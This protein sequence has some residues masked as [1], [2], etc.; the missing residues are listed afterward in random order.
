MVMF[1]VCGVVKAERP[2]RGLL[3]SRLKSK[4]YISQLT[5]VPPQFRDI[6]MRKNICVLRRIKPFLSDCPW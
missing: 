3:Q 6:D 5:L 2:R 4:T 1:C